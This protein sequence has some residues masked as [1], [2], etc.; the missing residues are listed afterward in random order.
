[1]LFVMTAWFVGVRT[2]AGLVRIGM[3]FNLRYGLIL[4]F[5]TVGILLLIMNKSAYGKKYGEFL[6]TLE[7]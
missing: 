1:M 4:M 7:K 6:K 5:L 2:G 3:S